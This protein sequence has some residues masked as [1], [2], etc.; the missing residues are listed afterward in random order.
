MH[1]QY[2]EVGSDASQSG[3]DAFDMAIH[4]AYNHIMT[5]RNAEK[6]DL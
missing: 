4:E 3:L 1:L 2:S 6:E 5:K